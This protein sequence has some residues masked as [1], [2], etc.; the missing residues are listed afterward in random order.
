[1]HQGQIA[2]AFT[3]PGNLGG[4][5]LAFGGGP[6]QASPGTIQVDSPDDH[7]DQSQADK[8]T[9]E[10]CRLRCHVSIVIEVKMA[11]Y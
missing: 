11:S 3:G 6:M 2:A 8:P 10:E 9:G 7:K 5:D 1:M 4:K